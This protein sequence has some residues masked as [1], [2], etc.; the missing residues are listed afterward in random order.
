MISILKLLCYNYRFYKVFIYSKINLFA[1]LLKGPLNDLRVFVS[2][3][4]VSSCISL[5]TS[6]TNQPIFSLC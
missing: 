4:G 1:C 6:F 3:S 2:I 5:I